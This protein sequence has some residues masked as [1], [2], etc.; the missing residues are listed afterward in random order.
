H[1]HPVRDVSAGTVRAFYS[2]SPVPSAPLEKTAGFVAIIT[3][4]PELGVLVDTPRL[5]L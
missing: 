2:G 1:W 3:L 4:D 5:A